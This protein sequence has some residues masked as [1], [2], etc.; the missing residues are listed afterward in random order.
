MCGRYVCSKAPEVYG[1]FYKV[2]VPLIA[3][4]FNVAPAQN[5]LVVR[6][7]DGKGHCV[8]QR[9]GLIPLWGSGQT[10]QRLRRLRLLAMVHAFVAVL[11]KWLG[12]SGR[13]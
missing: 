6:I 9:W 8:L 13:R 10:R 11:E 4:K 1:S 2:I 7:N 3:P 12:C 5:V